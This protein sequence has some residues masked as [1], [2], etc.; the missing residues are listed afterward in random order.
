MV[1]LF[2]P[3]NDDG[4]RVRRRPLRSDSQMIAT[5]LLGRDT[6]WDCGAQIAHVPD[7]VICVGSVG[8]VKS[9]PCERIVSTRRGSD[10]GVSEA[11]MMRHFSVSISC[12]RRTTE[13]GS[14]TIVPQP[15]AGI[16][17]PST[18]SAVGTKEMV[19]IR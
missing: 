8:T 9:I 12:I 7:C 6:P 18:F 13:V 17:G 10:S 11:M 2:R 5:R 19:G 15:D 4:R 14:C 1:V 16:D 3:R